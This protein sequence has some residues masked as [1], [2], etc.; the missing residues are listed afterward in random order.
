MDPSASPSIDWNR[1]PYVVS[2]PPRP[3][4]FVIVPIFSNQTSTIISTPSIQPKRSLPAQP[5]TQQWFQCRTPPFLVRS[6]TSIAMPSLA[7]YKIKGKS[8]FH[9]IQSFKF[10]NCF[11][12]F[13]LLFCT[14]GPMGRF[15]DRNFHRCVFYIW[16]SKQ[17]VATVEIK[18][19]FLLIVCRCP[20]TFVLHFAM[21]TSRNT[22]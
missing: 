15:T 14:D 12:I 13:G 8:H 16:N 18:L 2:T 4:H 5:S 19:T 1:N 21:H 17:F 10:D 6:A 3:T 20:H 11:S 7:S 22:K 9:P